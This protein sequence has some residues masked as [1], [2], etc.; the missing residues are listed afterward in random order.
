MSGI[1]GLGLDLVEQERVRRAVERHGSRFV[2]RIAGPEEIASRASGVLR[3]ESL[4]GLFAAKEAVLKALGTGWA[5]GVGFRQVVVLRSP[6][7]APVVR[8]DGEAARRAGELGVARVHLSIT[9]DAGVA[10]AVAVLEGPRPD[11]E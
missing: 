1:L 11:G 8:L 2:D 6:S 9:H 10:A 7:G 3:H 5:D 4:A